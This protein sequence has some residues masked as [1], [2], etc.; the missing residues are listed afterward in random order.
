MTLK[1][2]EKT[3]GFSKKIKKTR[4]KSEK[5]RKKSVYRV[6]VR[7]PNGKRVTKTF[8]RKFDAE[9]FKAELR[10]KKQKIND[11]GADI[12]YDKTFSQFVSYWFEMEVQGRKAQKTELCYRSDLKNYILPLI[13]HIKLKHLQYTHAKQIESFVISTNK[14]NRTVNKVMMVAKTIMNDAVKYGYILKSPF[15]GYPELKEDPRPINYWNKSEIY[16]FLEANKN[17]F[18][19]DVY[20]VALNTGLRLGEICGLCWDRVDLESQTITVSRT[21]T[22]NGLKNTTKTHR[23]RHLPMNNVVRD[24]MKKRF[25]SKIS[26]FVFNNPDG[27]HIPYDHFSQRDFRLAQKR[28][29]LQKTIRFHDLRHTYASHFVMNGG[30]IFVLQKLLGHSDMNTTM[31]YAHL[32]EKYMKSA[33]EIISF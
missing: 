22:R 25:K 18:Y 24:I 28:A 4:G 27:K 14:A 12:D 20:K 31:I 17:D 26:K 30:D 16:Q 2:D 13:G 6:D 8:H 3:S 1:K 19:I 5:T 15:K 23:A 32:S 7:M 29:D 9:Q 21:L 33:S 10:I 11:T